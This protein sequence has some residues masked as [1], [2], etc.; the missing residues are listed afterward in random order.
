MSDFDRLVY[1]SI[2]SS[3]V[4]EN[5]DRLPKVTNHNQGVHVQFTPLCSPSICGASILSLIFYPEDG[6]GGGDGAIM[7]SSGY[8]A[9]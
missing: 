7:C 9:C 3:E 4:R 2:G 6:W 8:L 5:P 1:S